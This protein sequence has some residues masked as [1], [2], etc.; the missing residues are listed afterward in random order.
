MILHTQYG[1]HFGGMCEFSVKC[2]K[3]TLVEVRHY[4]QKVINVKLLVAIELMEFDSWF[5]IIYFQIPNQK[6]KY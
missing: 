2:T 3:F 4:L 6:V 5:H 1:P